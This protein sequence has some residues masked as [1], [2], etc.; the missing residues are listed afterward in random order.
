MKIAGPALL[1]ACVVLSL[2]ASSRAAAASSSEDVPVRGGIAALADAIPISPAPDR[3]RFLA[4]AI[5]VVYSWPQ[6]GPYSN[7]PMRRRIAAVL[8]NP[9]ADVQDEIPVPLSADL[10][11]QL[12]RKQIA[13]DAL[14]G[15][16]LADRSASLVCYG[17][18]G[19]DDE[20]LQ[21][22]AA[23]PDVVQRIVERA[24]AAFAAFGESVRIHEGHVV[25]PG[26]DNARTAWQ[27]LAG[28]T[29][30]RPERF[31]QQLF[32]IDRGRLAYLFDA[33]AHVDQPIAHSVFGSSNSDSLKR[34]AALARRVFP[35][36]EVST[37]PFARPPV[38]IGALIARMEA[39]SDST[40]ATVDFGPA[41]FWQ[42]VFGDSANSSASADVAWMADAVL[43][44]PARERER[45]LDVFSFT[46]RVFGSA[47]RGPDV[48]NA[49]RAFDSYPVLMLAL[50]RM[51]IRTPS[52]YV[53]AGQHAEKLT[54]LDAAKGAVALSQ[55]Q[56]ALAL[57]ERAR[58]V[59]T[60]DDV[61]A[62]DLATKLFA[63]R[64]QDGSYDGAVATWL[65]TFVDRQRQPDAAVD[66]LILA[67]VAGTPRRDG[68]PTVEWEGQR[69]R[70]DPAAA[71]LHRLVRARARQESVTFA[72]TLA[73]RHLIDEFTTT[74]PT[75]ER[76]HEAAAI[77][78]AA[79][80]EVAAAEQP[81]DEPIVKSL[82][83][84]GRTLGTMK[85][86]ADIGEVRRAV[87]R[88]G[89]V[90]DTLLGHALV[91]LAY[92]CDLG[93]PDGTILIAGDP[94]R[95]HDFGYDQAGR[96]MR[97]KAM[98]SPASVETRRGPWHLVGS[99]LAL[100]VAMAPL[101]LR[102]I[103]V[104]RVPES[105]MLNLMHRDGFAGTVAVMNPAT[106]SDVQ[107]DQ[108]AEFVDKGRRRLAMLGADV[109]TVAMVARDVDLDGWRARALSW[110]AAHEPERVQSLFSMTELLVLGGG[111]PDAFNGWGGYS[112]KTAGC[113]CSRLAAPGEWRHWWGLSQAG[114][115]AILVADLPLKVAVVLHNF[116]LP[117]VL[118][119]P[120]LAAA[121]QDFVDGINPTDGN[122]WL[123]LARAA[124]AVDGARFEDYIA[125]ATADGPLVAEADGK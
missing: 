60:I 103:N 12:L 57:L 17:L 24:P 4:E 74:T 87:V 59:R 71:E 85:R 80:A 125:A 92:A 48:I 61:T 44:H 98:W 109:A 76:V 22:Y 70:V 95:L 14:I 77:I 113:L 52:T 100:D 20:T 33:L 54:A 47:S 73:V 83:E 13:R 82:R 29:L 122:D 8:A 116:R 118:A 119:K 45:R 43:A 72:T 110:T 63:L 102:R 88:L 37:A 5:R 124:Q 35:E 117:A 46:Q 99:V 2:P 26:G 64:L 78:E 40:S 1:V 91:S 36:W 104:D 23:H 69:Y 3:A 93:D 16:I 75:P 62:H 112:F 106:L 41:A 123:T 42:R 39:T 32:E 101:A 30:D 6:T 115:P 68:A 81:R 34:M 111:R 31:V 53:E 19:A 66:E 15:A 96:D 27:E 90:A 107:Q 50:E 121:M 89:T 49:A 67:S 56:G 97:T 79:A 51:N 10:W 108:I 114:L 18:A 28:E 84:A 94:S 105:P 21:F 58:R 65:S 55:F 25:A 11:S 120:V 38:D 7:E 9:S 86:S